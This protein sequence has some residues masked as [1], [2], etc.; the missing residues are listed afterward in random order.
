MSKG[1]TNEAAKVL[2]AF[3]K[4]HAAAVPERRLL[5][6]VYASEGQL[7]LAQAQIEILGRE[8]GPNSP[9]PFVEL[10]SA[11]ELAHRFD[12]ALAEYDRAAA[13][14]PSDPLGPLTGGLRSAHWG[15][16]EL[17]E[18]RLTEAARRDP[19]DASTWHALGL[20]RAKLGNLAGAEQAYQFGLSADPRALE[21]H[22]GLATLALLEDKPA[23]ALKHYDA[24]VAARPSFAD[25]ELGRSF[26]LLK[27]GRV[28]DA[29]AA[30]DRAEKLGANRRAVQAQRAK[31]SELRT[32]P[33]S[34]AKAQ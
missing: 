31:L 24:V 23:D 25:A 21:N 27:L 20:V 22:I 3:L 34:R 4:E 11:L 30:L 6:R 5:G 32:P 17:A 29:E 13:I 15:E 12:E 10:G 8:L 16:L 19:K 26:T 9:I 28:S 2:L 7:G 18:P 1:Q 14:A 33:D